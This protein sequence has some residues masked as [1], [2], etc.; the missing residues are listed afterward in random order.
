MFFL[1]LKTFASSVAI[2]ARNYVLRFIFTFRHLAILARNLG[3][4]IHNGYISTF[5]SNY[6]NSSFAFLLCSSGILTFPSREVID[7]A[8]SVAIASKN[9]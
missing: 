9:L 3:F 1:E 2:L 8:M 5:G 6:S 4:K 7:F